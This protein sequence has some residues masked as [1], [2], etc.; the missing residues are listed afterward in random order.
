MC[1]FINNLQ[2]ILPVLV[3]QHRLRQLA[4]FVCRYPP[5]PEG[6]AFEAGNLQTLPFS[7]TST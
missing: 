2:Q 5:F 6:D 7:I 4:H 1:K 3:F